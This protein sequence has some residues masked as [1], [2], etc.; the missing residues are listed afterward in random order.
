MS[1]ILISVSISFFLNIALLRLYE[2]NMQKR[3]LDVYDILHS[4]ISRLR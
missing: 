1:Q 3:F 4:L 2:R